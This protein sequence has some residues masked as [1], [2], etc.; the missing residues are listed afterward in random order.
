MNMSMKK[1]AFFNSIQTVY[2]DY[3]KNPEES[4]RIHAN[5]AAS[6]G[7]KW[8]DKYFYITERS[9]REFLWRLRDLDIEG[10]ELDEFPAICY[11]DGEV[12]NH[13]SFDIVINKEIGNHIII[14]INSVGGV[15]ICTNNG[16]DRYKMKT[17]KELIEFAKFFKEKYGF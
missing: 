6:Y 4:R 8:I 16:L 17:N 1:E 12:Q 2:K 5:M 9:C 13:F 14:Y 15:S 10:I 3:R 7:E 11:L